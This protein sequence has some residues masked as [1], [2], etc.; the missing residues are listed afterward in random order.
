MSTG[1]LASAS[2]LLIACATLLAAPVPLPKPPDYRALEP[3]S[4]A[5]WSGA[6]L[7]VAGKLTSVIAGPVGLS[8]PPLRTFRMQIQTDK[9]LR[10]SRKLG[11][12]L[13]AHYSVRQKKEPTFPAPEAACLIALKFARG[14]WVVQSVTLATPDNLKQAKLATSFPMGWTIKEGKLVSPWA[15]LARPGKSNEAAACSVTGRPVLLVGDGVSFSA[16]PVPPAVKKQFANPDGD[17]EYRLTV[18]N[19]TDQKLTVPAL[20]T[21][22]KTVRWSESVVIRCQDKNYPAPGATGD[23]SGLKPVTLKPG[24]S[25]SGVIQTLALKGPAWPRGGYR[26]EFQFCLGEKSVTQSFYYLSKH[27]DPIRDAAQKQQGK[28]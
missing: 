25:L 22:G 10:G 17:G 23:I 7:L 14:T 18:K 28:K 21:D 11:K 20:L 19:E 6:E 8:N 1:R 3:A 12:E 26:I 13:Q 9:V 16:E 24:E 2:L 27:H 15:T 4:I 5:K